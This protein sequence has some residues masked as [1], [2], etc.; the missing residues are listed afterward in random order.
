MRSRTLD[1]ILEAL[2]RNK[3]LDHVIPGELVLS[4]IR[5][6]S[7]IASMSVPSRTV[8]PLNKHR[9]F[10][11]LA[12]HLDPF[13]PQALQEQAKSAAL[14][15]LKGGPETVA[16]LQEIYTSRFDK[17]LQQQHHAYQTAILAAA[18]SSSPAANV[19]NQDCADAVNA[20]KSA[21]EAVTTRLSAVEQYITWN[22]PKM[23]DG[24]NFGVT[25]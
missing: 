7:P 14:E 2:N 5:H 3:S 15:V 18:A 23:E 10:L 1:P 24:G 6:G 4:L 17:A 8:P 22:I 11:F 9:H 21:T 16:Q 20:V 25:V 13:A 12:L 19:T